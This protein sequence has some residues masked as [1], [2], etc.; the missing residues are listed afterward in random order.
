MVFDTSDS[1]FLPPINRRRQ[2]IGLLVHEP[3]GAAPFATEHPEVVYLGTIRAS[4]LMVG[5][6]TEL[7][8]FQL[9]RPFHL[10]NLVNVLHILLKH[11]E[12][13]LLLGK[14]SGHRVVAP[15][16]LVQFPQTLIGSQVLFGEVEALNEP[17]NQGQTKRKQEQFPHIH[18]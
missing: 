16:P 9:I 12:A 2:I 5:H 14:V 18:C 13:L 15:P 7:V 8:E 17:E 6:V 11:I 4:E 3:A 1:S 10:V